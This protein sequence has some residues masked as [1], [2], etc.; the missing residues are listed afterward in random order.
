MPVVD[1]LRLKTKLSDS[2]MPETQAQVLVEELDE[3]LSTAIAAQVATKADVVELRAAISAIHE[4]FEQVDKRFEQIDKR[5]EQIDKRF[6][7]M[8]QSV[9]QRF[10]DLNQSVNQRFNDL[11]QSVAQIRS[12][13]VGLYFFIAFGFLG[14][15]L[16]DLIFR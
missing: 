11:N 2:G 9:N 8:N 6:D 1:T 14:M 16:K 3:V 10:G 5:F 15:I 4:R 13:L 12:W 7:D